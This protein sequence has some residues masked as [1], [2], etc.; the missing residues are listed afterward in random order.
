MRL[1]D[2]REI[3][4][5]VVT[6][7]ARNR[8]EPA[9]VWT[10]GRD[11]DRLPPDVAGDVGPDHVL[12]RDVAVVAG[13]AEFVPG[14]RLI[15]AQR[16]HVRRATGLLPRRAHDVR[17]MP[18]AVFVHHGAVPSVLE[19]H[20]GRRLPLYSNPVA[21]RA[22]R[23][24]RTFVLVLRRVRR[25]GLVDIEVL[26][27]R[28][29]H[30][31][32]PR[33]VFVVPDRDAGDDR[34]ATTDDVPAGRVQVHEI[35]EGGRGD[36]PVRIV[37]HQRAAAQRVL[38]AHHP[39]VAS[40]I[41]PLIPAHV[42]V[43]DRIEHGEPA[44]VRGVATEGNLDVRR[45]EAHG[46]AEGVV[47]SED[48]RVQARAVDHRIEVEL[49]RTRP[50]VKPLDLLQQSGAV[51]RHESAVREL[52]ADVAQQALMSRDHNL[53]RPFAGR[54]PQ[55]A[56]LGGDE[57][58]IARRFVHVR[59][60]AVNKGADDC[61]AA[62]MVAR[63]FGGHATAVLE[64]ARALVALQL[65]TAD[66]LGHRA[67]GLASPHLELEGA[68]ARRG[69]ALGE[70][71][72]V[73][74]L[75]VDV[76]DAPPVAQHLHRLGKARDA[77]GIGPRCLR[78][79]NPTTECE[80]RGHECTGQAENDATLHHNL[81]VRIMYFPDRPTAV[82]PVATSPPCAKSERPAPYPPRAGRDTP[83]G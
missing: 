29:E 13:G 61:G 26:T 36:L 43:G 40:D 48:R 60:Y 25:I 46:R 28:L 9:R 23:F 56:E 74:V 80:K 24:P 39:V 34:L 44:G 11:A 22:H 3:A 31:E 82:T 68:I 71:E 51:V 62:R 14:L 76:G 69:V 8:H 75:R 20:L 12:A 72:I 1:L 66:D 10:N 81:L 64:Q 5:P 83:A 38:A 65:A 33:A 45:L 41:A 47:Q 78:D 53:G 17:K 49:R 16:R 6:T 52:L 15:H 70:K 79:G 35:P 2:N 55:H 63:Q 18:S 57:R 19:G 54:D 4:R 32:P 58:R 73:L 42:R 7:V 67:R 50:W 37:G 30:G 59:V 21:D 27:V 77:K